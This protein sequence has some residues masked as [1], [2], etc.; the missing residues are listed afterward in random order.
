M[1]M[2]KTDRRTDEQ[3]NKYQHRQ[4][5]LTPLVAGGEGHRYYI[6]SDKLG[7]L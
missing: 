7:R 3:T 4:L 6:D 5:M 1:G 2:G